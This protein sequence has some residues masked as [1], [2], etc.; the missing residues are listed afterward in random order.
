M[1]CTLVTI[2]CVSTVKQFDQ[3][4]SAGSALAFLLYCQLLV[5][6][7]LALWAERPLYGA[8]VGDQQFQEFRD[9]HSSLFDQASLSRTVGY[10]TRAITQSALGGVIIATRALGMAGLW[11]PGVCAE[12]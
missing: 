7:R 10:A 4:N 9:H 3:H 6:Q 2:S 5:D 8:V 11:F 12:P 1:A